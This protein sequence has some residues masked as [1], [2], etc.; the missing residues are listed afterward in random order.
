MKLTREQLYKW[1]WNYPVTRVAEKLGISDSSL[2]RK[3][4]AHN[5]PTPGRGYWRRVEQGIPVQR[6]PLPNPD[7]GSTEVSVRVSEARA[8]ELD[9]LLLPF[10]ESLIGQTA[11]VNSSDGLDLPEALEVFEGHQVAPTLDFASGIASPQIGLTEETCQAMA[12][13]ADIIALA[14]LHD[15]TELARRFIEAVREASHDC[16]AATK[17]V[18]I[19]WTDAARA[20]IFES[21][22][23]TC[24]LKECRC[25]ASG[26]VNP[27]WW[28]T[29][30][31]GK[32]EHH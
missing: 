10:V 28:I 11:K 6:L 2:A 26:R 29:M 14:A 7:Q 25:V 13:P 4:R 1:V 27:E 22:P 21:D 32:R 24:V 5:V 9:Q 31:K 18:L 12:D 15:K 19:L 20:T 17:A 8:A 30:Q 23:T 16:D 3:C